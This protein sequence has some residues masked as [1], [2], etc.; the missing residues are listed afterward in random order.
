MKAMDQQIRNGIKALCELQVDL[1]A[2]I[3]YLQA[4]ETSLSRC[5]M[6][7]D[8]ASA[9]GRDVRRALQS[10]QASR[11]VTAAVEALALHYCNMVE[12]TE[13]YVPLKELARRCGRSR[14]QV[15]RYLTA[16]QE[17]GVDVARDAN[18]I[19]ISTKS[20]R[21]QWSRMLVAED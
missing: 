11:A 19:S 5:V 9:R 21:R 14:R 20:L 12:E 2:L 17:A 6:D 10:G 7:P 13:N 1:G 16:L 8:E 3:S 18:G 15:Q 4:G